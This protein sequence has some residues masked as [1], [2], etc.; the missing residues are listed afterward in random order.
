MN[1][2]MIKMSDARQMVSTYTIRRT[3]NGNLWYSGWKKPPDEISHDKS[4]KLF[5]K[6]TQLVGIIKRFYR[7]RSVC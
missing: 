4:V 5:R 1:S 7:A 6:F 3:V 2:G